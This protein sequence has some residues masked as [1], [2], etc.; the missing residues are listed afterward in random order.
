MTKT[1][2][3]PARRCTK[4]PPRCIEKKKP[5]HRNSAE[6][7]TARQKGLALGCGGDRDVD[8]ATEEL[9]SQFGNPLLFEDQRG[10]VEYVAPRGSP[11]SRAQRL[12]LLLNILVVVAGAA[13]FVFQKEHRLAAR[14]TGDRARTLLFEYRHD[15]R[16][17]VEAAVAHAN[18]LLFYVAPEFVAPL[19]DIWAHAK[20]LTAANSCWARDGEGIHDAP[21]WRGV[22]PAKL[23][24]KGVKFG[25]FYFGVG[26]R[27]DSMSLF[28][29][30]RGRP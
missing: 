19:D 25:G 4:L 8:G 26:G 22:W 18:A 13:D 17:V 27:A 10:F 11:R 29:D 5:L 1:R 14:R 3:H 30:V 28:G 16:N 15:D 24:M 12:E 7:L 20:S 21:T 6:F 2:H 9:R 23:S